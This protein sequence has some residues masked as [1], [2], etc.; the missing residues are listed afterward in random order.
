MKYIL[1]GASHN[2]SAVIDKVNEIGKQFKGNAIRLINSRVFFAL[3]EINNGHIS[4]T[5]TFFCPGGQIIHTLTEVFKPLSKSY[6]DITDSSFCHQC[7][8][9][10]EVQLYMKIIIIIVI[11]IIIIHIYIYINQSLFKYQNMQ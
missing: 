1:G 11:V 7:G 6:R 4:T 10:G 8:H 9:Y 2:V 5:A 3:L